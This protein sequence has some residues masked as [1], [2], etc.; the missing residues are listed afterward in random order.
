MQ[1]INPLVKKSVLIGVFIVILVVGVYAAYSRY[2][3][4]AKEINALQE[5]VMTL[6][7]VTPT[8][9]PTATPSATPGPT[10]QPSTGYIYLKIP[11]PSQI[12]QNKLSEYNQAI[13]TITAMGG[14]EING[15][16]INQPT[17]GYVYFQQPFSFNTGQASEYLRAIDK[18]KSLGMTFV[19]F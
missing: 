2:Q 11:D 10:T 16:L 13:D 4:Q 19:K 18:L 6:T 1:K 12:P 14:Y 9:S 15:K 3:E 17:N 7:R 5:K 8:A